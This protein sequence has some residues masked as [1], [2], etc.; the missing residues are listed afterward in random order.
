ME[1]RRVHSSHSSKSSPPVR[2]ETGESDATRDSTEFHDAAAVV[3]EE[4]DDEDFVVSRKRRERKD[5]VTET[6]MKGD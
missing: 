1:R 3:Q 2:T 6:I 5:S 4:G